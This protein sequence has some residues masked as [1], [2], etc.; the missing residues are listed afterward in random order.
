MRTIRKFFCPDQIEING[1]VLKMYAAG[2]ASTKPIHYEAEQLK[3]KGLIVAIVE[4]HNKQLRGK[5]DLH[6]KPYQ[7]SKFI[8]TDL[9][10]DEEIKAWR[11]KVEFWKKQFRPRTKKWMADTMRKNNRPKAAELW[12]GNEAAQN[13]AIRELLN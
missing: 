1:T 4:V 2:S 3:A 9:H 8:F 10:T 6:N 13:Q 12:T 5:T 7:P 11:D